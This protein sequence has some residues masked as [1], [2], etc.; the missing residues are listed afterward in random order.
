[1]VLGQRSCGQA[2][3]AGHR[4]LDEVD[5]DYDHDDDNEPSSGGRRPRRALLVL[6][7]AMV[8]VGCSPAGPDLGLP[9]CEDAPAVPFPRSELNTIEAGAQVALTAAGTDLL[10]EQRERIAGL[11]LDVDP[12]GWVRLDIPDQEQGSER[13]G[14][15]LRDIRVAFDLRTVQIGLEFVA[16][17]A[18]IRLTVGDARLRFERGNI[19]VGAGGNGACTLENGIFRGDP[20]EHFLNA[21]LAV[22]IFPE[23][24]AEGRFQVRVEI[25]PPTVDRLDIELGVDPNLPECSDFGSPAE[26]DFAC[27]ASDLGADILELLY[28]L[29]DEQLNALLTPFI[30]QAVNDLAIQYTDKPLA[31]EGAVSAAMLGA[32]L[33]LPLDAHDLLYRVAPTPEGFTLRTAGDRGDGLGLSLDLGLEALDHPCVT[34]TNRAPLLEAGPPPALTGYDGAGEPYH[35]GLAVARATLDRLLWS[36]WRSGMLCLRLDTD[37]IDMLAGQRI[38]TDTLGLLLPGLDRLAGGPRPM[39]VVLDPQIPVDAF[40]LL[41]L[42]PIEDDGGVPQAGVSVT[43]PGLG[44]ELYA[45]LEGRWSRI[46]AAR[47]DVAVDVAVQPVDGTRLAV[48]IEPPDIGE[49]MVEYDGLVG[50]DDLPALLRLVLDL[51]TRA[52]STEALAVDVDLSGMVEDLTGLPYDARISG[53]RVDGAER[54]HLSVLTTLEPVGGAALVAPVETAA[55]LRGVEPGRAIV[56][57]EAWAPGLRGARF[58]HRLDGGPWRPL[59]AAVDGALVIDEPLLRVPGEHRLAVRAVAEGAYR[60]LDPTPAELVIAVPRP[61]TAPAASKD[62]QNMPQGGPGGAV[63]PHAGDE[64]CRGMPG[65]DRAPG[66]P[67]GAL[68]G[69]LLGLWI[70]R[71]VD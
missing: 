8:F 4:G 24:D 39:M 7:A 63:A 23:V 67:L 35:I 27:G 5:D 19:W 29:F 50:A 31:L 34:P 60:T 11:L 47:T 26:C 68:A 9:G 54:D 38:D 25:D 45:Y 58:Q 49:L 41:A 65:S 32:M 61:E 18:R 66:G 70:R 30:E 36:L 2:T 71:R 53:L 57:V 37:D 33:P 6:W 59:R 69:I 21:G 51:A 42:R 48:A 56:A 20:N 16:D 3:A 1:M 64:G 15:G 46:F 28:G 62:P 40:P 52:L 12:D 17:P 10:L 22:D 13:F 43:V 55:T 44:I 14:I